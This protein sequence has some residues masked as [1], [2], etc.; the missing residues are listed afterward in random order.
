MYI[1]HTDVK[2]LRIGIFY[3]CFFKRI[4]VPILKTWR[5]D[6]ASFFVD[7]LLSFTT[8]YIFFYAHQFQKNVFDSQD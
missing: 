6:L 4:S 2:G 8:F 7:V 3:C 1:N 5:R